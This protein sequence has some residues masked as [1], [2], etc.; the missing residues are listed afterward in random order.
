LVERTGRRD[1]DDQ[2]QKGRKQRCVV[3][4][5]GWSRGAERRNEEGTDDR[6]RAAGGRRPPEKQGHKAG[7]AGGERAGGGEA[8]AGEG[9]GFMTRW[10][11]TPVVEQHR[12]L[13]QYFW[14]SVAEKY[15]IKK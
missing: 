14:L 13:D 5:I 15:E 1:G 7:A 12:L 11:T 10:A 6:S 8:V 3:G 2:E 4:E 9:A